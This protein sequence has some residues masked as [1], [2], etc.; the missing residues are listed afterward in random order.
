MGISRSSVIHQSFISHSSV[1]HQSFISR[2]SVVHQLFISCSSVVHQLF[3]SRSSVVPSVV[4]QSFIS[5]SSV[6]H[7]LS[8]INFIIN[9]FCSSLARLIATF[10][11][12]SLVGLSL[13]ALQ[14]EPP[15]NHPT[16]H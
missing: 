5:R 3:I 6:V 7:Q 1:V 8:S 10:K 11:R 13:Q 9:D 4:H 16:V 2:S 12:F 15:T 14:V